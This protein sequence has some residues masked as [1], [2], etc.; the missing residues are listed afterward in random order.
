LTACRG[1][2]NIAPSNN[3]TNRN[4]EI[5]S[6]DASRKTRVL[7][8]VWLG[9]ALLAGSAAAQQPRRLD[10]SKPDE[11]LKASQKI[12]CSLTDGKPVTFWWR[13]TAYS[14]VPGERDRIL[15]NVEG[16]NVR[17]C[18]AFTDPEKGYGYRLVSREILLYLDPESNQVLRKWKNPWTSQEVEVLHV[19]NDPVNQGPSFAQNRFKFGGTFK[20]G[21]FFT[22][23]EIPLFYKNPLGGEYQ[24]YVGGTYHAMEMFNFFGYEAD[25]LD[26]AKDS[27]TD[28]TVSWHRVAEW[29]PWMEMGDRPGAMIIVSVGKRLAKWDDLSD[30]MKSEISLNYPAYTAPPPLDDKRPNETSWTYFKKAA[31]K[32]KKP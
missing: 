10:L 13:G 5:F 18:K 30:R 15:F 20:N 4:L 17:A 32:K 12:Q 3:T 24:E 9:A 6:M 27:V 11:A 21:R 19:A 7:A 22:S 26:A 31:E 29:L 28:L 2:G 14:R 8:A 23:A 1:C 25:L 16:M